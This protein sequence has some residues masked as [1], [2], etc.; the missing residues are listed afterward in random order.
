MTML[1]SVKYRIKDQNVYSAANVAYGPEA[2]IQAHPTDVRFAPESGHSPAPSR[3]PLSAI[4]GSRLH[5][6]HLSGLLHGNTFCNA[7]KSVLRRRAS[8]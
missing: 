6:E 8:L 1:N 3:C 2:D 5:F 7:A 4:G